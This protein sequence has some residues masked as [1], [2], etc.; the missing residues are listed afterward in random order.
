MPQSFD[1][2]VARLKTHLYADMNE[3]QRDIS[4]ALSAI[5][6]DPSLLRGLKKDIIADVQGGTTLGVGDPYAGLPSDYLVQNPAGQ[7]TNVG[8]GLLTR[9]QTR[10]EA[11]I[12]RL[13][14]TVTQNAAFGNTQIE[15]NIVAQQPA[16]ATDPV[17]GMQV[18]G[19]PMAGL[20]TTP[21][22]GVPATVDVTGQPFVHPR[23]SGV[24]PVTAGQSIDVTVADTYEADTTWTSKNGG[25]KWTP[26]V[27]RTQKDT[28]PSI[29][30]DFQYGHH[31]THCTPGIISVSPPVAIP[32]PAGAFNWDLTPFQGNGHSTPNSYWRIVQLNDT[33]D[34]F[35]TFGPPWWAAGTTDANGKMINLPNTFWY[36]SALLS[37]YLERGCASDD[38]TS[39]GWPNLSS[40]G[41]NTSAVYSDFSCL[42]YY[43]TR[44]G[45]AYD[46]AGHTWDL[47]P[48]QNNWRG[49]PGS[50]WRIL[51][52]GY[53]SNPVPDAYPWY[54]AGTVDASGFL[55]G[56]P[57]NISF[58]H[59]DVFLGNLTG[60]I[61][62][63][64]D[65]G[66]TITWTRRLTT[67]TPYSR[68]SP[69][70]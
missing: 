69:H 40:P 31:V 39:I 42:S 32:S 50:K 17:T 60:I 24:Q 51:V 65:N 62:T 44:K 1:A 27:V 67:T 15:V 56:L 12:R 8:N 16:I 25:R 54:G 22:G 35:P 13:P 68:T 37:F 21:V 6:D 70:F 58:P 28:V 36:D 61:E 19:D 20:T 55:A 64:C 5:A 46:P 48:W 2:V 9:R 57:N 43:V 18:A 30:N 4:S 10:V 23:N 34:P 52:L 53:I 63:G 47:T 59:S 33:H 41:F 66:T 3:L 38:M 11:R 49:Y 45:F 7:P 29:V 26:N 14:A